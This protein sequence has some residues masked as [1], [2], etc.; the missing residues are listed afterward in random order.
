MK[1][2]YKEQTVPIVLCVVIW[3]CVSVTFIV[4]VETVRSYA[5]SRDTANPRRAKPIKDNRTPWLAV[6]LYRHFAYFSLGALTSL[7]FTELAKAAFILFA[8]VKVAFH[9]LGNLAYQG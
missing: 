4:L 8:S 3:A 7:L 9:Y 2:P 1:H 5:E 6:E